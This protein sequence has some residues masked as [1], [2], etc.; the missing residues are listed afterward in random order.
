MPIAPGGF[1]STLPKDFIQ[2][3]GTPGGSPMAWVYQCLLSEP[4]YFLTGEDGFT[5]LTM[6][7]NC[8]GYTAAYALQL[9]YA[10]NAVLR[11]IY[12]GTLSDAAQT[13]VRGV[14]RQPDFVDGFDPINR[15]F[16]RT[17]EYEVNYQQ[18]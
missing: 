18:V 6:R 7:I 5:T 12:S 4:T 17:V 11:G 2:P 15:S 1:M 10:I 14:F 3:A 9:Y 16:V 13:V 8:H